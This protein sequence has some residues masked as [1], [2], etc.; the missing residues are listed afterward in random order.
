MLPGP[1][2]EAEAVQAALDAD[3]PIIFGV[4]TTDTVAQA[5]VRAEPTKFNRGGEAAKSAIEMATVMRMIRGGEGTS[6]PKQTAGTNG[7]ARR[8]AR[9]L[10]T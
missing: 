8:P 6:P 2:T 9:K 4:L 7:A 5:I 10:K 3:I 1:L